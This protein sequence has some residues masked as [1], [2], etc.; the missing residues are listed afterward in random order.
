ML[1][2]LALVLVVILV[3]GLGCGDVTQSP[4]VVAKD[5]NGTDGRDA[6]FDAQ[7]E[8]AIEAVEARPADAAVGGNDVD[9]VLADAGAG[10]RSEAEVYVPPAG[11]LKGLW[12]ASWE[13]RGPC[14]LTIATVGGGVI[15]G[16]YEYTVEEGTFRGSLSGTVS[17]SAVVLMF[18]GGRVDGVL[19]AEAIDGTLSNGGKAFAFH[20]H[21][22]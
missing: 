4:L 19:A 13:E 22:L 11:A 21:H 16:S 1:K 18:G 8:A 3:S 12:A 5:A 9:P 2:A 14:Q 20:A 10:D 17:G 15:S 6:G 7:A